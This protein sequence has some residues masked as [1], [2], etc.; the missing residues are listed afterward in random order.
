[1]ARNF[2][3]AKQLSSFVLHRIS[4]AAICRRGYAAEGA[5][6][7]GRAK[8]N[9]NS[10]A[11]PKSGNEAVD[12]AAASWYPDPVTGYYRPEGEDDKVIDAADLR[13]MF[14][15]NTPRKQ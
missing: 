10:N 15:K 8:S 6:A 5:V 7:S 3:T 14:L 2:S 1:M 12:K 11:T 4:V 9:S 13:L